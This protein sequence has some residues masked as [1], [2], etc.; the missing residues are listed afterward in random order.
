LRMYINGVQVSSTPAT[1]SIQAT[2]TPLRIGGNTY[3]SEFFR[4]L[5]DEVR[6]YNRALSPAEIQTDMTTPIAPPGPADTT[7]PSTVAGLIATVISGTQINLSWTAATDNIAVTGYRVERCQTIGCTTFAQIATPSGTTFSD[8]GLAAATSYSYRV[9]AVDAAGNV[10]VAYS[11]VAAA[12]TVADT[13]PPTDPTG[14]TATAA[15]SN[16]INLTWT[17]STDNGGSSLAGYEVERCQGAGC[18]NFV[19]IA[20]ISTN[21]YTD[22]GLTANTTYSYRIRAVDGALNRSNYTSISATTGGGTPAT[23]LIAAYAFNEASGTTT[24]DISGNNN[25]GT[26][27]NGPIRAAAGKFG[28][29]LSFDGINDHVLVPNSVSLTLTTAMTL[30]AWVN[31]SVTLSSWKAILQKEVDAY[32]LTASSDQQNRPASGFTLSSGACCTFTYAT[33]ALVPNT[34]THVAATYDGTQFRMYINGVQVSSTPATGSIQPTTTP[35]RIG[36]NTYSSEFFQGLIDEVR[37][38]N[39]ALTLTEIQTDMTTPIAP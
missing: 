6:I 38:Y 23:G 37:I 31:P 24:A 1:G 14:L 12:T 28:A 2:T 18:T 35:L 19:L 20:S 3:G 16:Q 15:G 25:T 33:A 8:T 22:A 39:R 36:G 27:T 21:S 9:K 30:E 4:G 29:A 34:W 32:F 7:P 10:S 11:N 13:T 26:L 17:A 5:I